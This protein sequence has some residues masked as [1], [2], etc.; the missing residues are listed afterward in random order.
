MP[1]LSLGFFVALASLSKNVAG[2]DSGNKKSFCAP[3]N[4]LRLHDGDGSEIRS[5][6]AEFG[7]NTKFSSEPNIPA[8][9][10]GMM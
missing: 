3:E 10:F 7:E 2:Q 6:L 8:H 9:V 1:P 5:G 4:Q